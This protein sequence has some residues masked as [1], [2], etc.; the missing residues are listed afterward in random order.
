MSDKKN[1]LKNLHEGK[2]PYF[3]L[4]VFVTDKQIQTAF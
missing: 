1:P 3:G 4:K 2:I